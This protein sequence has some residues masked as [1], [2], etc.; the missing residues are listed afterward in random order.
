ME[1]GNLN[2][3]E[4]KSAREAINTRIKEVE[5]QV[6]AELQAKAASLG[7]S[8]VKNGAPVKAQTQQPKARFINPADPSQRWTGK[9]RKPSWMTELLQQG[10]DIEEFRV[11]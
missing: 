11:A 9:G 6:L 7:F 1:I 8:L 5:T 4:L 2:L 10:R 3:D